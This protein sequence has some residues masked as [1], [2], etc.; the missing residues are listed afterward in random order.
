MGSKQETQ[1][2]NRSKKIIFSIIVVG[3][4]MAGKT[5][6][7]QSYEYMVT[8]NIEYDE[9]NNQPLN[10]NI[11][12]LII[13]IGNEY[14]VLRITIKNEKN[15]DINCLVK[16]WDSTGGERFRSIVLSSVKNK[17][18]LLLAYDITMRSTFEDLN[19][20]IRQI[21]DYQDISEFP[22]IIVGCKVDLEDKR[23]VSTEEGHTFAAKYKCPFFETSA[24]T[25]K[26]VKEAF[27]ALIQKV[28][29]KN[30]NKNN[31]FGLY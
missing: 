5:G 14:R 4:N 11:K 25:G 30:K 27:S 19:Q 12:H 6:L 24:R 22:I 16:V 9:K 2:S 3:S 26:G 13:N 15:E 28:Y 7:L 21:N 18:G 29:E 1:K 23:E 20:W 8:N 31:L 10:T 17:Q